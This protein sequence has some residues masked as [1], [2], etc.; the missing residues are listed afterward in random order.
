MFEWFVLAGMVKINTVT[1]YI[2]KVEDGIFTC[3]ALMV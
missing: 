1:F 3:A 2:L